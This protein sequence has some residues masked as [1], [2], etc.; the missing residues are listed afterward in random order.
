MTTVCKARAAVKG[1]GD[2]KLNGGIS[3]IGFG[4]EGGMMEM[5]SKMMEAINPK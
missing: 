5:M 3:L 4:G 2:K 1:G